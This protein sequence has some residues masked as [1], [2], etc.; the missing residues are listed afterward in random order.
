MQ[1]YSS[2]NSKTGGRL[3]EIDRQND[4]LRLDLFDHTDSSRVVGEFELAE[5]EEIA[6]S[7]AGVCREIRR[8]RALAPLYADDKTPDE[9][10]VKEALKANLT[11]VPPYGEWCRDPKA[12]AGKGYC[13]LDPTCG[14]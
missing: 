4:T 5:A 14:D 9:K 8:T 3:L 10:A 1:C 6:A 2:H 7:I 13:P 11:S 12:C